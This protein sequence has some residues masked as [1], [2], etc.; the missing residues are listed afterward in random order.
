[1]NR[2]I[3]IIIPIILSLTIITASPVFGSD[4]VI[5]TMVVGATCGITLGDAISFGNV[6][7][8]TQSSEEILNINATGS[9]PSFVEVSGTDWLNDSDANMVNSE[10]TKFS[11][12]SGTDFSSKTALGSTDTG[13]SMGPS[14]QNSAIHTTYWQVEL[15][16]N[17]STFQGAVEQ[18]I[19]FEVT[20]CE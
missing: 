2:K 4:E 14:F 20:G 19:T 9:A 11:L 15:I 17:D 7:V 3:L 8:G 6:A 18:T 13:V 10:N 12:T 1:M 16:L 5:N